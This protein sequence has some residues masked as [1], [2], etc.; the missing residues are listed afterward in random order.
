MKKENIKQVVLGIV[1]GVAVGLLVDSLLLLQL[2]GWIIV[3]IFPVIAPIVFGVLAFGFLGWMRL[4]PRLP[5]LLIVLV[6]II[7]WPLCLL[8]PI[9]IRESGFRKKVDKLVPIYIGAEKILDRVTA[10][11]GDGRPHIELDFSIREDYSKV[12]DFYRNE[13]S[14][15]GWQIV[16]EYPI[17]IP[18][19]KTLNKGQN[20]TAK[21]GKNFVSIRIVEQ[22]NIEKEASNSTV[23]IYFETK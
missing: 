15:K 7:S 8:G 23:H 3:F 18:H 13:L 6:L 19:G 22:S 12:I 20:I 11:A 21:Q 9:W 16:K 5:W 1:L 14:N 10:I 2:S 4:L 17:S